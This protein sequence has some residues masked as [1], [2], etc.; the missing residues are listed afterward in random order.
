VCFRKL[1]LSVHE[2]CLD[3]LFGGP[4][5]VEAE[6]FVQRVRHRRMGSRD[7]QVAPRATQ[8]LAGLRWIA[9]VSGRRPPVLLEAPAE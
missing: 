4:L 3:G 6:I 2:N 8:P 9:Q 1:N 5:C 7:S